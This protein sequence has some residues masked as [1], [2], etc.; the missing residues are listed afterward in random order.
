MN[1]VPAAIGAPHVPQVNLLPP[2]VEAKRSAARTRVKLLIALI[3]FVVLIAAAWFFARSLRV[4]AEDELGAE[5]VRTTELQAEL[6]SYS[7]LNVLAD[8]YDN[9]VAA[10][11]YVGATDIEW[12]SQLTALTGALPDDVAW[13]TIQVT[14]SSPSS[15]SITAP[16]VFT[17]LGV[18][19]VTFAGTSAEPIIMADYIEAVD[20]LPGYADTWIDAQQIVE[21]DGSVSWSYSGSTTVTINALSGRIATTQT[22]VPPEIMA[23]YEDPDDAEAATSEEAN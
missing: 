4:A 9:S 19:T 22:E 23:F 11:A 21:A 16:T 8:V 15:G 20:A 17:N 2:E 7:Y 5:Q 12:A 18:G 13:D 3:L 10:R 6:A 14:Q 1:P